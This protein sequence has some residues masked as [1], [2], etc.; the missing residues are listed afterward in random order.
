M[1][2]VHAPDATILPSA[3]GS[4]VTLQARYHSMRERERACVNTN[5]KNGHGRTAEISSWIP[6]DSRRTERTRRMVA[7]PRRL[8]VHWLSARRGYCTEWTPGLGAP[9]AIVAGRRHETMRDPDRARRRKT[10]PEP[11]EYNARRHHGGARRNTLRVGARVSR[12]AS[13][14]DPWYRDP[15][16]GA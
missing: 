14:T 15:R 10:P 8:K 5:R 11:A 1:G 7:T 9:A 12:D 13:L 4:V 16:G 3:H 6:G 2:G